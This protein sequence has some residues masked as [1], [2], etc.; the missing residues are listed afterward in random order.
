MCCL[1]ETQK[2]CVPVKQ[3]VEPVSRLKG[4][5][6]MAQAIFDPG[7]DS[8]WYLS[9]LR[10]GPRSGLLTGNPTSKEERTDVPRN[11]HRESG[12]TSE[13]NDFVKEMTMI[14]E[15]RLMESR[16][17]EEAA[18]AARGDHD[19]PMSDANALP[20]GPITATS[21]AT[22]SPDSGVTPLVGLHGDTQKPD[23]TAEEDWECHGCEEW[24]KPEQKR[25]VCGKYSH[26]KVVRYW[27]AEGAVHTT[28]ERVGQRDKDDNDESSSATTDDA[29]PS[30]VAME[31]SNQ[32]EK[33]RFQI[34]ADERDDLKNAPMQSGGNNPHIQTDMTHQLKGEIETKKSTRQIVSTTN[35]QPTHQD[36]K[37]VADFV[38]ANLIGEK[39]RNNY[40]N[41]EKGFQ[42]WRYNAKMIEY[43]TLEADQILR[44]AIERE[45]I[46][47]EDEGK[48]GADA[49]EDAKLYKLYVDV[50]DKFVLQTGG[51][52]DQLHEKYT[53]R[54]IQE[55]LGGRSARHR[56]PSD[57]VLNNHKPMEPCPERVG[58]DHIPLQRKVHHEAG[59]RHANE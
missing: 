39:A 13:L 27:N 12:K 8:Q 23:I 42:L 11:Y 4:V 43:D 16:R 48:Q 40:E 34:R 31:L 35:V 50:F 14:M 45:L 18:R 28:Q 10:P 3:W 57:S 30:P 52:R 32:G 37:S 29:R 26:P 59:G 21:T 36:I 41:W 24:R 5:T 55:S 17:V 58:M 53:T 56:L 6:I 20:E 46:S 54:S 15:A 44:L 22:P 33:T 9:T 51:E 7:S 19:V 25:C 49:M 47:E 38:K 2:Q 1:P